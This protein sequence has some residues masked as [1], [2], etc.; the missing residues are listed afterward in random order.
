MV[1]SNNMFVRDQFTKMVSGTDFFKRLQPAFVK[2]IGPL[3]AT[4]MNE[5]PDVSLDK[6]AHERLYQMAEGLIQLPHALV[7]VKGEKDLQSVFAVFF[8]ILTD[9]VG[10]LKKH[11]VVA[12]QIGPKIL[13]STQNL[14]T[15]L[16]DAKNQVTGIDSVIIRKGVEERVEWLGNQVAAINKT[17]SEL[18]VLP[19]VQGQ[20]QEKGVQ[21]KPQTQSQ[22]LRKQVAKKVSEGILPLGNKLSEAALTPLGLAP[23]QNL[24]LSNLAKNLMNVPLDLLSGNSTLEE[25]LK[26]ITEILEKLCKFLFS[27]PEALFKTASLILPALGPVG[28][29]VSGALQV[30]SS[31][32]MLMGGLKMGL[33]SV[34]G[35]VTKLEGQLSGVPNA[36]PER[37]QS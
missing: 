35:Q 16:S 18:A 15:L 8:K 19:Q 13:E 26:A 25:A 30:V 33:N 5:I 6:E 4:L 31:N 37:L 3:A 34:M 24:E 20:A 17:V 22:T 11:P 10:F 21:P 36:G 29:A 2:A 27:N 23:E 9:L 14:K 1:P 7:E 32:E 12:A 28:L